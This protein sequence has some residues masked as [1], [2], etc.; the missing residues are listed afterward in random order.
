MHAAAGFPVKSAWLKAI[1]NGN[2]GSWTGLTY[3][4]AEKY[5]PHSVET[6]KGHMVQSSQGVRSTKKKKHQIHNN[7]K[8]TPQGTL[9]QQSETEDIPSQ[10][11]T[12]ELQ[13][14]DHPISK[15][16]TD[17]CGRFLIRSRSGNEYII[18]AYHCDSNKILQSPFVN[19]KDKHR[20]RAYKSIM[21][22][23]ENRGYCVEVQILDNEVSA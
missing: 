4:N 19:I 6:L 14:W 9:H 12:Q 10:Q 7:K 21:Q 13:V 5:F 11:K 8:K 18:I 22:K 20:I 23:L 3:N 15:L 17:D 2:F 16:Y 1:K